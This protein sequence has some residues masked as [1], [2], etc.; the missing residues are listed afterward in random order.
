MTSFKTPKKVPIFYLCSQEGHI[1]HVCPKNIVK[2]SQVC[3]VP[4][5]NAVPG[6]SGLSLKMT[7]IEISGKE[8]CALVDTGSDQNLL[9]RQFVSPAMINPSDKKL[10]CCV[11]GDEKLLPTVDL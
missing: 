7:T 2:L 11:Y 1:K 9:H 4:R 3:Y 8:L 6:K 10:I 5:T